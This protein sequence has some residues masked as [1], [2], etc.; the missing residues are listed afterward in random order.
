MYTV[1]WVYHVTRKFKYYVIF[2]FVVISCNDY[3]V[4]LI[5]LKFSM[6]P[7]KC[8]LF[9]RL[10]RFTPSDDLWYIGPFI[11]SSSEPM[12]SKYFCLPKFY[13]PLKK[14]GLYK[15]LSLTSFVSTNVSFEPDYH[16]YKVE[17]YYYFTWLIHSFILTCYTLV[18][19]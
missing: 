4:V 6:P 12:L 15:C 10:C 2:Y 19:F 3:Y 7:K 5:L 14:C 17:E 11:S 9:K 13:M 16:N 8:G 18:P 1:K